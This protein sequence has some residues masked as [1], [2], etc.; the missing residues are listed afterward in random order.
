MGE[1]REQL[2]YLKEKRKRRRSSSSEKPS[3][4]EESSESTTKRRRASVHPQPKNSVGSKVKPIEITK[5]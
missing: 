4:N 5:K 3:E 2:K 1:I